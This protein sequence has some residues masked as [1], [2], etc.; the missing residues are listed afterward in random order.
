VHCSL[1]G[2]YLQYVLAGVVP[3][4]SYP[5]VEAVVR[6]G[7]SRSALKGMESVDL[8]LKDGT[9]G[10]TIIAMH[11]EGFL[12]PEWIA[13]YLVDT[14][15]NHFMKDERAEISNN[16]DRLLRIFSVLHRFQVPTWMQFGARKNVYLYLSQQA[17][18]FVSP[19]ACA[20]PHWSWPSQQQIGD[21]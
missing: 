18:F 9:L 1:L 17:W 10:G 5:E 7:F 2:F 15:N 19:M 16:K 4:Q 13:A 14:D 8:L 12:S 3:S 6:D 20:N 21:V 11:N